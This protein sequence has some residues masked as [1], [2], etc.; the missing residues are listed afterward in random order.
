M[1]VS[2]GIR[3]PLFASETCNVISEGGMQ[4]SDRVAGLQ[5]TANRVFDLAE[6]WVAIPRHQELQDFIGASAS[7]LSLF[8][9]ANRRFCRDSPQIHA[10]SKSDKNDGLGRAPHDRESKRVPLR[11]ENCIEAYRSCIEAYRAA[12]K[13]GGL[14]RSIYVHIG[15]YRSMATAGREPSVKIK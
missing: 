11:N 6:V 12:S 9:R 5:Q 3:Y 1:A 7:T 15:L 8:S 10:T 13:H 4:A 14:Y 2:S